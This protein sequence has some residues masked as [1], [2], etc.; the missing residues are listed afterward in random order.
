M[1]HS[2]QTVRRDE[3]AP[4]GSGLH[5][6]EASRASDRFAYREPTGA[7]NLPVPKRKHGMA[8]RKGRREGHVPSRR[9]VSA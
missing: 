1:G 8:Y 4:G 6:P 9:A 2:G 5:R 7:A 3:G